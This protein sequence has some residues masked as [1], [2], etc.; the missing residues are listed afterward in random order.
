MRKSFGKSFRVT[1]VASA[2]AVAAFFASQSYSADITVEQAM[3]MLQEVGNQRAIAQGMGGSGYLP[4]GVDNP[5]ALAQAQTDYLANNL[6]MARMQIDDVAR[7]ASTGTI[8]PSVLAKAAVMLAAKQQGWTAANMNGNSSD[9]RNLTIALSSSGIPGMGN[10]VLPDIANAI[11]TAVPGTSPNAALQ[12]MGNFSNLNSNPNDI[13]LIVTVKGEVVGV[14]NMNLSPMLPGGPATQNAVGGMPPPITLLEPGQTITQLVTQMVNNGAQEGS[15][16]AM[17]SSTGASPAEVA[18]AMLAAGVPPARVVAELTGSQINQGGTFV[19]N[20][21]SMV[22]ISTR[23][24]TDAQLQTQYQAVVNAVSAAVPSFGYN[25]AFEAAVN[26]GADPSK[27]TPP[28][29][30][31]NTSNSPAI[32]TANANTQNTP[33][34]AAPPAATPITQPFA[35]GTAGS[36]VG[37]NTPSSAGAGTGVSRT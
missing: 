12:A 13:R 9:V 35:S 27:I 24:M 4:P 22:S 21:G 16:G 31:G 1:A 8:D 5:V 34:P 36:T 10:M 20:N 37:S 32:N 7:V 26:A 15:I 2:Y 23:G 33:P 25:N 14:N 19:I 28:T 3:V 29:A 30:S 11:I 18:N 6:P 17:V